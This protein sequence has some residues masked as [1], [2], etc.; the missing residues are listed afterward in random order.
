VPEATKCSK[1][2]KFFCLLRWS[3]SRNRAGGEKAK[4]TCE[5][6]SFPT[7]VPFFRPRDFGDVAGCLK[8]GARSH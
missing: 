1:I 4:N 5:Q 7:V 8:I 3:Q 6:I 2:E